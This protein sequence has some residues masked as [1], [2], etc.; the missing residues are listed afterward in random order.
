MYEL[1]ILGRI[2]FPLFAWGLVMGAV[3]TRNI[4]RYALRVLLVGI[5]SQPFYVY[6]MNHSW[7]QLN[8]FATLLLGLLGIAAIRENRFG[9]RYWGPV[10]AVLAACTIKM[11][12]GFQ[13]VLFILLLYGARQS[14]A[15]IIS[16]MIAYCLYWGFGTLQL[17]TVF[18]LPVIE[19]VSFLP[20]GRKLF[21]HI[22]QIEFWAI[23]ALPFMVLPMRTHKDKRHLPTWVGYTFYPGHPAVGRDRRVFSVDRRRLKRCGLFQGLAVTADHLVQLLVTGRRGNAHVRQTHTRQA[24]HV[25][26]THIG[27]L[28]RHS[29]LLR[30][31][32]AAR[33]L[34]VQLP[35]PPGQPSVLL[36]LPGQRREG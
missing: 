4:W 26:G 3:Y 31:R 30:R 21:A 28:T 20:E 27:P 2:A 33:R 32:F 16:F 22:A 15:S 25:R 36:L 24:V 10:L 29:G 23:L 9:S 6:G 1:R 18:G 19:Q 35:G 13:G 11:D 14:R 12:Y 7:N 34:V 5:V 8:V 17:K